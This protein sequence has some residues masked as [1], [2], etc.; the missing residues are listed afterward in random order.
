MKRLTV[1]YDGRC[2]LC[3]RLVSW[4]RDQRQ[5]VRLECQPKGPDSGDDLVVAADTGEV[6]SG[7]A[8]WLMVLWAL[9]D[10]RD[11]SY[12]LARP[13]LLPLARQAFAT[14]SEN[15]SRLSEWMG[16]K[17]DEAVVAELREVAVPGC[18]PA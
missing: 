12:R 14:L 11:W 16:L 18:R 4:L 10:Y 9:D 7:D 2:G 5:L 13:A 6:W 15:R 1:Y 8:A 17:A 3:T